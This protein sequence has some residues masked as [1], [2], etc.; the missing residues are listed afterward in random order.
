MIG[1]KLLQVKNNIDQINWYDKNILLIVKSI[2]YR[3]RRKWKYLTH[4]NFSLYQW[5]NMYPP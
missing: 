3:V 4:A 1:T 5:K 2:V